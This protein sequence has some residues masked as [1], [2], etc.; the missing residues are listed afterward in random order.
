VEVDVDVE[1]VVFVEVDV[2]VDVDVEVEV[3]V[4]V[5][6]EVDV[7]VDVLVVVEVEV[8]VDVE[9]DVLVVVEVEVEVPVLVLVGV[10][11]MQVALQP[12]AIMFIQNI[13][14]PAMFS[15]SPKPHV[16]LLVP[17]I[18]TPVKVPRTGLTSPQ[19][20]QVFHSEA[21]TEELVTLPEV[22]P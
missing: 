22:L 3:L 10:G 16:I 2:D 12:P 5:D 4:E 1:V 19:E 9:V 11:V 13:C 20:L 8:E 15:I 6:V 18:G 14:F 21:A 7:D 17:D